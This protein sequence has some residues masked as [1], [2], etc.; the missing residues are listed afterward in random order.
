MPTK[1]K[2][3]ENF[4]IMMC[5]LVYC[6]G[7]LLEECTTYSTRRQRLLRGRATTVTQGPLW[8]PCRPSICYGSETQST[9]PATTYAQSNLANRPTPITTKPIICNYA[10][11][12]HRTN[13]PQRLIIA[14]KTGISLYISAVFTAPIL[15]Q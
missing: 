14:N 2:F 6:K 3:T 9:R 7:L 10:Q 11:L 4:G 5:Y 13:Q 8:A 15:Q 12:Q 1:Q